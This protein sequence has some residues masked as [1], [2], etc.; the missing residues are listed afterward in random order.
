ME[1]WNRTLYMEN[2]QKPRVFFIV[3]GFENELS[4]SRSKHRV[5][6]IADDIDIRK[7]E[8][9]VDSEYIE[10]FING[11]LGDLLI[12]KEADFVEKIKSAN[13]IMVISGKIIDDTNLNYL[14][15]CIG[16][17]ESMLENGAVG[18]LDIFTLR[19]MNI[20]EWQQEY[21]NDLE[22]NPKRHVIILYS[23]EENGIW[24][25]SRGMIKFGR[26]D[27]S[28]LDV[29]K[30]K[31]EDAQKVVNRFIEYEA[32]GG[33]YDLG[34]EVKMENIPSGIYFSLNDNFDNL[35]FNNVFIETKWPH[36][37]A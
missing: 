37:I 7:I 23:H 27:I 28:I 9:Q 10:G 17:V 13:S 3:F 30:D 19:W 15:N 36:N 12:E 20:K 25:H 2:E 6:Q 34:K 33:V 31:F 35:D 11:S 14:R 4:V 32:M 24:I 29:P 22:L 1:N 8:R 21:F 16:I 18:V 5:S 26:P